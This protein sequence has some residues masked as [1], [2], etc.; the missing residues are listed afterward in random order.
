MMMTMT[1][2]DPP[3]QRAG[4]GVPDGP[5]PGEVLGDGEGPPGLLQ[6]VVQGPKARAG[7]HGTKGALENPAPQHRWRAICL[8]G[9]G[10]STAHW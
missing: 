9:E 2:R 6:V 10:L 4:P 5:A 3:G 8:P 1:T 7:R